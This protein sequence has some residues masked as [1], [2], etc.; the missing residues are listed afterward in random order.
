MSVEEA[1]T[2]LLGLQNRRIELSEKIQELTLVVRAFIPLVDPEGF[3]LPSTT[4]TEAHRQRKL[5]NDLAKAK[6]TLL[7]V[8][9]EIEQLLLQVFP[10]LNTEIVKEVEPNVLPTDNK[11]YCKVKSVLPGSNASLSGIQAGDR[12]S[13]VNGRECTSLEAFKLAIKPDVPNTLIL[14]APNDNTVKE[15]SVKHPFGLAFEQ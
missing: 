1:K 5:K 6:S 7:I 2:Q 8:E 4:M 14:L 11:F 3:P 10:L 12:I 13:L 9:R 15:I